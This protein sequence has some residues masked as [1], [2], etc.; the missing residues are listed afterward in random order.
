P[1]LR[2]AVNLSARHF[3]DRHLLADVAAALD[4]A[5]MEPAHLELEITESMMM[6]DT[7]GA[8]AILHGLKK[9]GVHIAL[10]DFGVGYSSLSHLKYFP[11][12]VIKIDRSFIIDVPGAQVDQALA[13][14]VIAIGKSLRMRVVA[15][16]VE[17]E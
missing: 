11:I 1:P 9:L 13:E 5:G 10:D 16:G 4:A 14:A 6:R 8:A 7:A 12:D 3:A 2:L 15:E 17:L